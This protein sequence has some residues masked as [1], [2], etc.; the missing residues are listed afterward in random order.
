VCCV[1][2]LHMLAPHFRTLSRRKVAAPLYTTRTP[3]I[4]GSIGFVTRLRQQMTTS[5]GEWTCCVTGPGDITVC[6]FVG[7]VPAMSQVGR[8]FHH[9]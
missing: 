3:F 8:V 1:A 5:L 2:I 4:L 6:L 7:C 9:S